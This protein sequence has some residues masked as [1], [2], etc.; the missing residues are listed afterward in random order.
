MFVLSALAFIFITVF[1]SS[2]AN[3][4]K[5][6]DVSLRVTAEFFE[7]SYESAFKYNKLITAS[8]SFR[9]D[10]NK[11][12]VAAEVSVSYGAFSGA[13]KASYEG[14]T[15]TFDQMSSSRHE[16]KYHEE[17][18]KPGFLQIERKITT[19]VIIDGNVAKSVER[20]L[21]DSV[22]IEKSESPQQLR[23][24]AN[25]YMIK[26][27]GYLADENGAELRGHVYTAEACV[28]YQ[29][30][31]DTYCVKIQTG[32]TGGNKG[33]LSVLINDVPKVQGWFDRN[34][35]VMDECFAELYDISVRNNDEDAW[36]GTIIVKG[37][38]EEVPL[39]CYNGCGGNAFNKEIVVDGDDNSDDQASTHCLNGQLCK[40]K[41]PRKKEVWKA[42]PQKNPIPENQESKQQDGLKCYE[43][44]P[45][46]LSITPYSN[47]NKLNC[48][49]D[50]NDYGELKV[51]DYVHSACAKGT[52]D[53]NGVELTIR[54]CQPY[55]VGKVGTCEKVTHLNQD[56][57]LCFCGANY[58][59]GSNQ[60]YPTFHLVS[61]I[62]PLILMFV[63]RNQV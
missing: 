4:E 62:I 51:C 61:A 11:L 18:Y 9:K 45:I 60:Q 49:T 35:I 40:L 21:V 13:A 39:T 14:I 15:D 47:M 43:C 7:K 58:C 26:N 59:N 8:S 44:N 63:A 23:Q 53:V 34:I 46:D 12:A 50:E 28:P 29:I 36:K 52:I 16:E 30:Q 1:G 56:I 48:L 20:E 27:F 31:K 57:K 19:E 2:V 32:P 38:G 41:L 54:K 22:P 37:N 25:E 24:R 3:N 33:H 10:Y 5:C 55:G 42:I 17:H 6:V